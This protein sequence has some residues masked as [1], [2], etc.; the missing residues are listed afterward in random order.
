MKRFVIVTPRPGRT[1]VSLVAYQ[2]VEDTKRTKTVYMGSFPISLDPAL[3][4]AAPLL[5]PGQSWHG[6]RISQKSPITLNPDEISVIRRWLE[7]HGTVTAMA[8]LQ[9]EEA[10]KKAS[11]RAN[12]RAVLTSEVKA[13]L[14]ASI[15]VR[16]V[17]GIRLK[18]LREKLVRAWRIAL[19][20]RAHAPQQAEGNK[21]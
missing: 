5:A 16:D 7:F 19:H 15:R 17:L 20:K 6:L 10:A 13:E 12:L 2:Y 9:R 21:G 1:T 11:E 14:L 8:R 18:A 3:L 4:E